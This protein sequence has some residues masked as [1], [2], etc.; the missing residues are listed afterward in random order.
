MNFDEYKNDLDYPSKAEHTTVFVYSKGK[1]IGQ[2][3]QFFDRETIAKLRAENPGSV[4]DTSTDDATFQT[5]RNLYNAE[6]ARL[7]EKFITDI[8]KDCGVADNKFTRKLYAIAYEQ[9]HSAGNSNVYSIFC[10]LVDLVP[11]AEQVYGQA[12]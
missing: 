4:T 10:D 9:G 7:E 11:I 8:M 1:V 12:K 5:A 6:S 2:G 3:N